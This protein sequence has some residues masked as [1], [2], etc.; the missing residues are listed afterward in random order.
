[1]YFDDT[2]FTL[3]MTVNEALKLLSELKGLEKEPPEPGLAPF[4]KSL[5]VELELTFNGS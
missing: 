5:K 2:N 3:T 4:L 1:M